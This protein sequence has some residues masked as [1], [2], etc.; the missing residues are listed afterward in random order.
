MKILVLASE[1]VRI[2][3]IQNYTKAFIEEARRNGASVSVCELFST[4]LFGK[5]SFGVRYLISMI[6]HRPD[7]VFCTHAGFS[8]LCLFTKKTLGVQYSVS[9]YGIEVEHPSFFE[10]KGLASADRVV[11]LFENTRAVAERNVP[12]TRGKFLLLPNSIDIGKYPLEEKNPAFEKRL[13]TKGKKVIYTLCRLSASERDNKGYEKVLRALPLIIKEIPDVRYILA[14]GGDDAEHVRDVVKE[15]GIEGYVELPGRVADEDMGNFYSL[16]DVFVFPSKREGF[17][18]IVLL[19]ALA[20][21]RP[22][23]GGNQPGSE[24]FDGVFGLIVDPDDGEALA[25]AVIKL[26]QKEVPDELTDPAT[27]RSKVDERY[28]LRAYS[29]RVAAYIAMFMR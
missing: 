16:A 17:P 27:L 20:C 9:I 29:T 6:F 19:E 5:F 23:V 11:Y 2:G 26:L 3:G 13:H 8:P 4:S 12:E 15:L 25:R 24:E 14:G 18:A 10:K 1:L 7:V 21:G 28:G 22:V